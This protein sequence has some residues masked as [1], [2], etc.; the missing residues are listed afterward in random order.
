MVVVHRHAHTLLY[1]IVYVRLLCCWGPQAQG[2]AQLSSKEAELRKKE[3]DL[4]QREKAL[5]EREEAL[6]KTGLLAPKNN[7]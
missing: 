4:D 7:W 2:D 1:G 5:T 3:A 6:R